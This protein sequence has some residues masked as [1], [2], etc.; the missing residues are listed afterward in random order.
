MWYCQA[1]GRGRQAAP[2]ASAARDSQSARV[3]PSALR[4]PIGLVELPCVKLES[5]WRLLLAAWVASAC[6]E[7]SS[8]PE[9]ELAPVAVRSMRQERRSTNKVLILDSS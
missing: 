3:A 7:V 2:Q 5:L 6:G 1:R 4:D 9:G 8:V